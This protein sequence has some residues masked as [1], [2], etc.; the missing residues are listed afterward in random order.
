[1]RS[2]VYSVSAVVRVAVLGCAGVIASGIAAL[3]QASPGASAVPPESAPLSS[4]APQVSAQVAQP[5][6]TSNVSA[7][8]SSHERQLLTDW[9]DLARFREKDA[10][11]PPPAPGQNRV[12]FMGDSITQIWPFH[13]PYPLSK[14][15]EFFPGKFYI[16]RGISGQ[17]TPQMLVR[18]RQDVVQLH[19]KVV[20]ILAGTND[21]AG[22]TGPESLPEIENNLKSMSD[23]A[24]AQGIQVVLCSVLPV[25]DYPW[26]PGLE[27]SSKIIA[28]NQWMK[29]YAAAKAYVYVDYYSAMVD[30]RGGLPPALSKDGVHPNQAGFRIMTP[31]VQ[32]GIEKALADSVKP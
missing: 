19:P 28:I 10:A 12:V 20:V 24:H 26:K 17:T 2:G 16:N 5:A 27:P 30:S 15:N 21:L 13:G 22:N 14:D 11:L 29:S 4:A 32:A 7:W 6:R 9:P 31:L 18:F 8:E 25:F 23:L 3:G 1:M